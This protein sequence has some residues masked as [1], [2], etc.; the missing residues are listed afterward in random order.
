MASVWKNIRHSLLKIG[1][2]DIHFLALMDEDGNLLFANARMLKELKLKN[3]KQTR[4][5]FYEQLHPVHIGSFRNAIRFSMVDE[6]P[7]PIEL[8]LKNGLYRR[9]EWKVNYL[10]KLRGEQKTFLCLG[11]IK[12]E[13]GAYRR[14]ETL[15]SV[16]ER[17]NYF[18]RIT[19]DAIWEWDM[20]TGQIYRNERLMQMIGYERENLKGLS[21]WLSRVHTED[22]D[23]LV[24]TLKQVT[25]ENLHSWESQYRFLCS[26]GL[27]KYMFDR[28]FVIYENGFPVKM[29]GS[30]TDITQ[31]KQME[32]Q[33]MSERQQ[34]QR[35][36]SET[37]MRVQEQERN[38]L[39]M[40]LHDNVNQLLS[41]I[42][43]YAAMLKPE[44]ESEIEI[45]DKII[46]YALLAI[47]EI[48]NLSREMVVPELKSG[49]L[50]ENIRK[51]KYDIERSTPL[52]MDLEIKIEE[53]LIGPGKKL[54]FFRI[55]Q[56]QVKNILKYSQASA[57]EIRL[58]LIERLAVLTINDNGVGFDMEKIATGV[59]FHSIIERA[60]LYH[61]TAHIEASPGKGCLI[62]VSLPMQE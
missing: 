16:Q 3:P 54:T 39:G 57:M 18:S 59:G 15:Q 32:D 19:S 23:A 4:I 61:G 9:M 34:R 36:N 2:A 47:D 58:E 28:G 22:R 8:Y 13:P 38:R 6:H 27:Y 56:E 31:Q 14:A 41:T 20:M 33:L 5:N 21:W 17:F 37:A 53:E 29:I 48:R 52:R 35:E 40:E 45:K 1:L 25:D 60:R 43:L 42:R 11:I 7:Q 24:E 62:R 44:A 12:H 30:L 26:D 51:M 55:I 50:E 46:E 10:P 49:T